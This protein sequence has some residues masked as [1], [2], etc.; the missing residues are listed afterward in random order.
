VSSAK[1]RGRRH[2]HKGKRP[3]NDGF[4]PY[5]AFRRCTVCD[6]QCY[7]TRAEAKRSARVNHPS[8]VMH[9]YMCEEDTGK[10]WWHL[11]SIPADKLTELRDREHGAA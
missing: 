2:L 8:Q 6:K 1:G 10:Q 5:M 9:V 3:V 4:T 7:P 11:S